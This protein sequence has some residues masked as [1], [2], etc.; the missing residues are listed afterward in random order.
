MTGLVE[1]RGLDD[2]PATGQGKPLLHTLSAKEISS[3]IRQGHVSVEEYANG[4]LQHI[5]KRDPVVHAWAYLDPALVLAQAR[6]LD[7]V[8]PE[9]RGPLHGVAIGVKDVFLTKGKVVP[10]GLV[11]DFSIQRTNNQKTCRHDTVRG[12]TRM[13]RHSVPTPSVSR[14]SEQPV[15][16]SWAKHT[17][18]SL[19][20]PL[21]EDLVRT[22]DV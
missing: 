4:L 22:H 2:D 8:H 9:D 7:E 21:W 19:L 18:L 6:E 13:N 20:P 11:H 16:L 10:P 3:L 12:Y 5:K 17:Q 15:P 1:V 14:R